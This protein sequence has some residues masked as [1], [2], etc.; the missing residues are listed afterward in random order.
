MGSLLPCILLLRRPS[1]ATPGHELI[2]AH[3]TK[4]CLPC[5]LCF[6]ADPGELHGQELLQDRVPDRCQL[7]VCLSVQM[8]QMRK[9]TAFMR[10]PVGEGWMSSP[11]LHRE[12]HQD[13]GVAGGDGCE[14]SDVLPGVSSP[15]SSCLLTTNPHPPAIPEACFF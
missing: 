2:F 1:R 11:Q 10:I 6:C 4:F 15:T 3:S 8:K 12:A 14:G 9:H 7:S 13:Y 5:A